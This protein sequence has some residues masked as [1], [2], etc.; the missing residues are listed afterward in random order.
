MNFEARRHERFEAEEFLLREAEM[1]DAQRYTEW[2]D[3]VTQDIIYWAPAIESVESRKRTSNYVCAEDETSY[4][5]ETRATLQMRVDRL[6][7]ANVWAEVPPSRM[8]RYI[9]NIRVTGVEG[10]EMIVRSNFF[11]F[12]SRLESEEDRYYGAREDRLRLSDGAL[13]LAR[14]KITLAQSV[15]L[16]RSITTFF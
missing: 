15:L 2:L 7:V 8:V 5:Y 14:R 11:L 10:D 13:K 16:S 6:K 1:L 4:F 3:T 12:R 9:S